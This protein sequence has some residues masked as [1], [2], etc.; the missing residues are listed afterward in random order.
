MAKK[1]FAKLGL[2]RD[3]D[4][5]LFIRDGA[6]YSAPRKKPGVRAKGRQ[7]LLTRFAG[8]GEMDYSSYLYFIDKKGDVIQMSRPK[9]KAKKK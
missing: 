5:L 2:K 9:R 1:V 8:K 4:T 6:V 3:G 7:K